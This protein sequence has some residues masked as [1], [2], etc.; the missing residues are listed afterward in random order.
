M[1]HHRFEDK[2]NGCEGSF[3]YA[4]GRL[5]QIIRILI[6]V[7]QRRDKEKMMF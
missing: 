3:L 2:V 6:K 4:K 7:K 1:L 5:I